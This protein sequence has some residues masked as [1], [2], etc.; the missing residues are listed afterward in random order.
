MMACALFAATPPAHAIIVIGG[1]GRNLQAPGLSSDSLIGS[2]WALQG[3]WGDW[4]GTPIASNYF[5][6]AGHVGGN[7]G[8]YFTYHD[9]KLRT[10]AS[11]SDPN[12]DLR[13]WKVQ[14]TF[15]RYA[16]LYTS[17]SEAGQQIILFGRG[18]QRGSE[19]VVNNELKGWY[20][21]ALDGRKSWGLNTVDFATGGEITGGA[22]QFGFDRNAGFNEGMLSLNDS[23]GGVFIKD[24]GSWKLAGINLAVDG[25]FSL[26]GNDAGFNAAIL[27]RGGLWEG[28]AGAWEFNADTTADKPASGY[29]TRISTSMLWIT[30]V[31]AGQVAPNFA[32]SSQQSI[33]A[34]P[35][36]AAAVAGAATLLLSMRRARKAA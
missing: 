16:Q 32:L 22:L 21:G 4:L 33:V 29:A 19:I 10:L 18:T 17:S 36:P 20:W 12:S 3:Q 13:I 9:R 35:E 2:G 15:Y 24:A 23:G 26:T 7:V 14:G 1:S 31:L 6:T 34:V 8:D 5:I 30:S 27:D 28:G 11:Y 25:P